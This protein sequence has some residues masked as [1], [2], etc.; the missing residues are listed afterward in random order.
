MRNVFFNEKSKLFMININYHKRQSITRNTKNNIRFLCYEV[1]H[2][3][4]IYLVFVQSF[5]DFIKINIKKEDIL[6]LYLFKNNNKEFTS[7]H[8]ANI[9]KRETTLH[10][11]QSFSI[12]CYRHVIKYIIKRKIKSLFNVNS[13]DSEEADNFNY[14]E[15]LQA[16]HTTKI[17]NRIYDRDSTTLLNKNYDIYEASLQLCLMFFQFFYLNKSITKHTRQASSIS[18]QKTSKKSRKN[19]VTV[20]DFELQRYHKELMTENKEKT[21]KDYLKLFFND[22]NATFKSAEQKQVIEEVLKETSCIT[23]IAATGS[24]KSLIFMLTHFINVH[25]V[26]LILTS[27]TAIKNDL[28]KRCTELHLQAEIFE[29]NEDHK[30]TLQICSY[31]TVNNANFTQYVV[32][33]VIVHEY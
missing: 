21:E 25:H 18:V 12:L 9:M 33:S 13:S 20:T 6:S 16:N 26:T 4:C 11:S 27:L 10:L 2:L 19:T 17:H 32:L 23:Y 7:E 22:N 28:L 15:D 5:Y 3:Q 24:E 31:E 14:I 8:L 1:S 29:E 30:A